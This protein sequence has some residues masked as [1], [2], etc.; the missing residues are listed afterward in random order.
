MYVPLNLDAMR[1][2]I[3]SG[4]AMNTNPITKRCMSNLQLSKPVPDPI[5]SPSQR[6]G[7]EKDR[8]ASMRC[9]PRWNTIVLHLDRMNPIDFY[10]VPPLEFVRH[11]FRERTTYAGLGS[12]R[13]GRINLRGS[14]QRLNIEGMTMWIHDVT[15]TARSETYATVRV[16][17]TIQ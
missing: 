7:I 9:P 17:P 14:L 13:S 15:S 2:K 4:E 10:F 11:W 5:G 16:G 3:L 8:N 1:L 12:G 6:P